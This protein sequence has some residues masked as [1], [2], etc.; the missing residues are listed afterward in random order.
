MK[1]FLSNLAGVIVSVA[2]F[3][4]IGTAMT[5]LVHKSDFSADHV[6][7]PLLLGT[8]A[9]LSALGLAAMFGRNARNMACYAV[10]Y[11]ITGA[12]MFYA[13]SVA[14]QTQDPSLST[15]KWSAYAGICAVYG[16]VSGLAGGWVARGLHNKLTG[17]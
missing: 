9:T 8:L 1:L 6:I 10:C 11:A 2:V 15:A 14:F 17:K 4:G 13:L 12:G 5:W 7:N 3:A 16:L